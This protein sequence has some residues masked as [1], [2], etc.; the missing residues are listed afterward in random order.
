MCI[1]LYVKLIWC[2]GVPEIYGRLLGGY[3]CHGIMRILLY[4]KLI[5]CSGVPQ[6]YGRLLGGGRPPFFLTHLLFY[7][8]LRRGLFYERPINI[9]WLKYI[10]QPNCCKDKYIQLVSTRMEVTE[11]TFREIKSKK[12]LEIQGIFSSISEETG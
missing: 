5:R 1:L 9:Y 12:Q 3:I 7:A 4:V 8:L 10:F 2:S 6:I 11:E